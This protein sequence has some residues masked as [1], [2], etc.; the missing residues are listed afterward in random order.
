MDS[1][2][3]Y[4]VLWSSDLDGVSFTRIGYTTGTT[5]THRNQADQAQGYYRVMSEDNGTGVV[6]V[7]G[8]TR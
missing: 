8:R 5:F 7:V 4:R 3:A 6:R 2:T 1:A